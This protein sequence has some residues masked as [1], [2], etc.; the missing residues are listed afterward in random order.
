MNHPIDLDSESNRRADPDTNASVDPEL[1]RREDS[2]Y[3]YKCPQF[4]AGERTGGKVRRKLKLP[5]DAPEAPVP[6]VEPGCT[7]RLRSAQ[8]HHLGG[9]ACLPG[10][11]YPHKEVFCVPLTRGTTGGSCF[12]P[13]RSPDLAAR[14]DLISNHEG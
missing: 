6:P 12:V 13:A 4:V 5:P 3:R 2:R 10:R 9:P 8:I 11:V 14:R 1:G 7:P